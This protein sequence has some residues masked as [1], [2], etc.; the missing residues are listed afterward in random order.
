MPLGGWIEHVDVEMDM[1][2]DHGSLPADSLLA[3]WREEMGSIT[4]KSGNTI[5][6]TDLMRQGIENAGF[7]NIHEKKFKFPLGDW[8]RHPIYQEAGEM[9]KVHFKEGLEGWGMWLLTS[10]GR[11]HEEVTTFVGRIGRAH[12]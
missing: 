10:I 7:V 12:V 1:R 6:V 2:C 3:K 4:E 5:L 11:S 8:P 9:N